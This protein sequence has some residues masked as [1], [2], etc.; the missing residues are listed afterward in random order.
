VRNLIAPG[1]TIDRYT[2]PG[3]NASVLLRA[4]F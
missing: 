2:Q 1:A 3:R 4:R